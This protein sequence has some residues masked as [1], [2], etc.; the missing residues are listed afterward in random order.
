MA[1]KKQTIIDIRGV[2]ECER[3]SQMK[4]IH[5]EMKVNVQKD[6]W[7]FKKRKLYHLRVK[8]YDHSLIKYLGV[9]IDEGE[10]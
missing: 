8:V 10:F 7:V 3:G 4:H 5:A 6:W 2:F 9:V 1:F